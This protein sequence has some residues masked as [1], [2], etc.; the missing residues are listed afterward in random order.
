MQIEAAQ[1]AAQQ[2]ADR[3]AAGGYFW[4]T[5]EGVFKDTDLMDLH[6]LLFFLISVAS[7]WICVR[8][9]LFTTVGMLFIKSFGGAVS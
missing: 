1:D 6:R 8:F 9:L 7:V 4:N 5:A 3:M 2:A